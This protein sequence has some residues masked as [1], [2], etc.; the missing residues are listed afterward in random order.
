MPND[1]NLD[2][3]CPPFLDAKKKKSCFF[4]KGA[5]FYWLRAHQAQEHAGTGPRSWSRGVPPCDPGRLVWTCSWQRPRRDDV[6][7]FHGLKVESALRGRPLAGLPFTA[8]LGEASVVPRP[9]VQSAVVAGHTCSD[10]G[11]GA[12]SCRVGLA[13]SFGS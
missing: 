8:P 11:G 1:Y 4:K 10:W 3:F 12:V 7:C 13:L 9:Q 6:H 2:P 5:C